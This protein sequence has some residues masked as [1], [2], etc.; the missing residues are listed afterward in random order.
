MFRLIKDTYAEDLFDLYLDSIKAEA[1]PI[2]DAGFDPGERKDMGEK[3]PEVAQ[4]PAGQVFGSV[5]MLEDDGQLILFM[6]VAQEASDRYIALKVS[7]FVEFISKADLGFYGHS[8]KYI[9]ELDNAFTLRL[10]EIEK[11]VIID[12]ADPYTFMQLESIFLEEGN[13]FSQRTRLTDELEKWQ[14]LFHIKEH[15]L[16]CAFRSRD[17][18][19]LMVPIWIPQLE[20]D[21][22]RPDKLAQAL[23]R[24]EHPSRDS[25]VMHKYALETDM[26]EDRDISQYRLSMPKSDYQMD[27]GSRGEIVLLPHERFV[28]LEMTVY[29][30]DF[31]VFKGK[32][33]EA[34]I[35]DDKKR[36]NLGDVKS[37]LTFHFEPRY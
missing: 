1:M 12:A 16:T 24:G 18:S 31:A 15:E 10:R 5:R 3:R 35:L 14:A 28:G 27:T 6:P 23:M 19:R 9:A 7:Q 36:H 11:A 2:S 26:A 32:L 25:R 13:R 30:G 29:C 8:G 22:K 20:M 34:L 4:I 21:L 33:P 17:A 37:R